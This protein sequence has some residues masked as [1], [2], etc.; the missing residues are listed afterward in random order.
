MAPSHP[1]CDGVHHIAIQGAGI[2]QAK[3]SLTLMSH[4]YY[5]EGKR[6]DMKPHAKAAVIGN[7]YVLFSILGDREQGQ[8]VLN[9]RITL[10]DFLLVLFCPLSLRFETTT[11]Q[12]WKQSVYE[13][14]TAFFDDF[15]AFLEG[16]P[17]YTHP[18]S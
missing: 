11:L 14:S 18:R 2:R 13:G 5:Y 4:H 8:S 10:F 12:R 3:E 7:Q 6:A 9:E 17:R 1:F 16:L 15:V